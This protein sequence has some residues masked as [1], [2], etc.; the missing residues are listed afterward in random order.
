MRI[1]KQEKRNDEFKEVVRRIQNEGMSRR[2]R[3]KI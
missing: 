1:K 3:R 2:Q